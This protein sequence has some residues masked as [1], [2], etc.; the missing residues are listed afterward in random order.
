MKYQFD[1]NKAFVFRHL[2][3]DAKERNRR[4]SRSYMIDDIP[5]ED[6]ESNSKFCKLTIRE[7]KQNLSRFQLLFNDDSKR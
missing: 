6:I 5:S 2:Y 3:I 7:S 4:S 1:V